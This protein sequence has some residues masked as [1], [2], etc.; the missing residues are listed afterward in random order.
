MS[1]FLT[2]LAT[3]ALHAAPGIRPRLAGRFEPLASALD[4][5]PPQPL[6]LAEEL[7]SPGAA[8]APRRAPAQ[9]GVSPSSAP[10]PPSAAAAWS[11][12]LPAPAPPAPQLPQM[13]DWPRGVQ[14]PSGESDE[15]RD[16]PSTA[17]RSWLPAR[18]HHAPENTAPAEPPAF[19]AAPAARQAREEAAVQ[20]ARASNAA[21]AARPTAQLP[22]QPHVRP[23]PLQPRQP[24]LAAALGQA[25]RE[26]D[27][28]ITIGRIEVRAVSEARPAR[29]APTPPRPR[30]TL[31]DYLKSRA[32]GGS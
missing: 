30:V 9:S 3:R 20:P 12:P 14:P 21:Q 17:E 8:P 29:A 10:P 28:Q 25:Q 1:D 31:E 27:L 32:G 11:A 18:A 4:L 23:A 24:E 16:A 22:L 19:P 7:E 6:D 2:R 5:R 15:H 13:Q 26:A